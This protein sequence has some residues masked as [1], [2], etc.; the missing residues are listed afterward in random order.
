[1]VEINLAESGI[2]KRSADIVKASFHELH[3]WFKADEEPKSVDETSWKISGEKAYMI[4]ALNN[5]AS[6]FHISKRRHL[7]HSKLVHPLG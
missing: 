7:L 3:E 2:L 4:G 6:I 5:V 1:M